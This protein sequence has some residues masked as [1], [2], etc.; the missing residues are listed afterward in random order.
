MN[1]YTSH[2][3][4]MFFDKYKKRIFDQDD[5]ALF[6]VLVR[7]YTPSESIFRELGDFLAHPDQKDRGLVVNS[8][9]PVTSFYESKTEHV[10]SGGKIPMEPPSGLGVLEDVQL[11]LGAIFEQSGI[12]NFVNEKDDLSFR[13]FVFCIIFLLSNFKLKIKNQLVDMKVN[14]GNSLNLTISYES[15]K[16]ES[17]YISLTVLRLNSVWCTCSSGFQEELNGYIVRRFSNGLLGAIPYEVD[18]NELCGDM[19]QIPREQVWPLAELK[20]AS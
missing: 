3:I 20:R 1:P 17:N 15:S 11:S 5:V 2:H 9:K 14:F 10:M 4:H 12:S 16:Y 7:D 8:F 6:I 13:E 19:K 18:T